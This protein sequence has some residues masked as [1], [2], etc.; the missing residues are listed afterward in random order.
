MK[1]LE[2]TFNF[3]AEIIAQA[4]REEAAYH[5]LRSAHWRER[6]QMALQT[7]ETTIGAKIIQ[8]PVTGGTEVDVIVDYG[9]PEAWREYQL[10]TRKVVEHEDAA[11]GF[12]VDGR[13]Y[14]SQQG[15]MYDLDVG[16]VQHFR[17]GGESRPD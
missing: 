11:E 12:D 10:S 16:D 17:L 9:D 15:R 5:K 13:T 2:H 4:A 14:G 7:V 1:R 6:Q 8:R 3:S